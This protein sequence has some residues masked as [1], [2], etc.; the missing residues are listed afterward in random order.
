MVAP[1]KAALPGFR[2]TLFPQGD[3]AAVNVLTK[4][5]YAEGR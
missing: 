1:G 4:A 5:D 3:L 2:A